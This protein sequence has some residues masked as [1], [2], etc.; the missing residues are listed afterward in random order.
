MDS[1]AEV[2]EESNSWIPGFGD[3][4]AIFLTIIFAV[5]VSGLIWLLRQL[6]NPEQGQ[7]SPFVPG[8]EDSFT[9]PLKLHITDFFFQFEQ[10]ECEVR[11]NEIVRFVSAL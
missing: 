11:E 1:K 10:D 3:E 9:S 4:V 6:Q 5:V 8:K 2:F 7:N